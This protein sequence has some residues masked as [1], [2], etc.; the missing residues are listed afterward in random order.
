M[1][2][3]FANIPTPHNRFLADLK[4]G[5]EQQN[6]IVTWDY[7]VFWACEDNFDI[8][9]IHWPEYLSFEIEKYLNNNDRIRNSVWNKLE[10][11]L[12]YWK[13]NSKIVYTRHNT[14]P[15]SRQDSDFQKLYYLVSAAADFITHFSN[16]SIKEFKSSYSQICTNHVVIP[17]HNYQSLP[18]NSNKIVARNKLG[19]SHKAYV[20][21]VFGGVKEH[22]KRIIRRAFKDIPV[23]NKVLL[24]PGW[25]IKRRKIGYI[26][27]RE[28]VFKAE[29]WISRL[30]RNKKINLGFIKED[31]A[32]YYLNAADFLFIPRTKELN[33]GNVALG[34]TFGLV[35]VGGNI[36]NIREILEDTGNPIYAV[37]DDISLKSAINDALE[38]KTRSHGQ[39]NK[40]I[41]MEEWNIKKV[42][43][44][45]YEIFN[46][47]IK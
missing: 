13:S 5:L 32:H 26:H 8:I 36:G 44:M 16:F 3:L 15:H 29:N 22:E 20:M 23:K 31:E 18:N 40:Q 42:V 12:L 28:W 9:H 10:Q 14:L 19:I 7:E 2:I 30:D 37:E 47:L 6:S 41:A 33:S 45:Y 27:I 35:V 21:L 17:H 43:A 1:R 4:N 25:K 34:F 46:S 11:C 24:A 38:L 39:N